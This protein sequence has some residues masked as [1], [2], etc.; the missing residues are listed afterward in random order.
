MTSSSR[1]EST[2]PG[3]EL[4]SAAQGVFEAVWRLGRG[5]ARRGFDAVSGA[6]EALLDRL[7]RTVVEN[8]LDVHDARDARQRIDDAAANVGGAAAIVGAP[9]LLR[10][11]ATF[12]RRGKVVPS[13]AVMAAAATTLTAIT[14]GMQHLYVLAS[15]LVQRLR[16]DG[17]RVDPAFVRRVAL[18]LYLD[19]DA[20]VDAVRANKFASVRLATDW[21]SHALP[22]F[23]GR[24][25]ESRVRRAA[26]AV[27]R[28]DLR[29]ALARF[30][31]ERAIDLTETAR[32]G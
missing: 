32:S 9:W 28:L 11:V 25:S 8:P 14:V 19:P 10:R 24:R 20:S 29:A 27:H 30:E 17:H 3:A 2:L 7:M 22:F 18:G 31:R 13:A 26:D 4:E 21:G 5:G 16:S 1:T 12:L 23:G 6:I 15:L